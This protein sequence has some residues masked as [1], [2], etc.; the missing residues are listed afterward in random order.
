MAEFQF[1]APTLQELVV[2]DTP[3]QIAGQDECLREYILG[4]PESLRDVR[5]ILDAEVLDHLLQLAK[6]SKTNRVIM[7]GAGIHLKVRRS[8]TGHVYETLH[9]TGLKP[10]P[11]VPPDKIQIPTTP[12]HA[13]K[14]IH[15]WGKK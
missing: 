8:R 15:R 6:Q 12:T 4:G 10:V 7:H 9:L 3:I 1:Q 14:L 13:K 11:E 5:M 2:K